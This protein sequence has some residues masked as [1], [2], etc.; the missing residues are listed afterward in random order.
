MKFSNN[1]DDE[2]QVSHKSYS[3]ALLLK[4][5]LEEQGFSKIEHISH[6]YGYFFKRKGEPNIRWDYSSPYKSIK[7]TAKDVLT[8]KI[9]NYEI[10]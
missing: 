5:L 8:P 10:Y 4:N 2:W 9:E 7:Y 1:I 6:E 3:N